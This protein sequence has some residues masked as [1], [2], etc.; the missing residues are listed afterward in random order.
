MAARADTI[1]A[2]L[3]EADAQVVAAEQ[4]SDAALLAV[5]DVG[6][7]KF[8]ESAWDEWTAAGLERER[9]QDR[10]VLTCSPMQR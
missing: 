4:H 10:V 7:L 6:L 9:G 8:L 2:A 5:H 1:L 3:A